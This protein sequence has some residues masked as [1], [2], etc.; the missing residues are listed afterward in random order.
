MEWNLTTNFIVIF[1]I[2]YQS[3]IIVVSKLLVA[4]NMLIERLNMFHIKIFYCNLI[5]LKKISG[6]LKMYKE[7]V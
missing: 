2:K 4:V 5:L 1:A 3:N 7:L 6:S